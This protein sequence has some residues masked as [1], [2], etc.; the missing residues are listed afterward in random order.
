MPITSTK[1]KLYLGKSIEELN[2]HGEVKIAL[3]ED[4]GPHLTVANKAF[5]RAEELSMDGDEEKSFVLYMRYLNTIALA[6]KTKLY[7]QNLKY[8][9]LIVV[10]RMVQ[11]IDNAEILKDSLLKRYKERELEESNTQ[12]VTSNQSNS[13]EPSNFIPPISSNSSPFI[14]STDLYKLLLNTPPSAVIL[15]CRDHSD[16]KKGVV[17]SVP[18]IYKP[19]SMSALELTLTNIKHLL[20]MYDPSILLNQVS[21]VLMDTQ[22]EELT[23]KKD[24]PLMILRQ[25]LKDFDLNNELSCCP[26]LL[27]GGFESWS[28][29][30]PTLVSTDY[31]PQNDTNSSDESSTTSVLFP[32]LQ[33]QEGVS[34]IIERAKTQINDDEISNDDFFKPRRAPPPIPPKPTGKSLENDENLENEISPSAPAVSIIANVNAISTTPCENNIESSITDGNKLNCV[35]N[36]IQ[37]PIPI[38][39][40]N[41]L[42]SKSLAPTIALN[43][44]EYSGINQSL[45]SFSG[46][47]PSAPPL[48]SLYSQTPII[49]YSTQAPTYIMQTNEPIIP[50]PYGSYPNT[51]QGALHPQQY[52]I[53]PDSQYY[54]QV[55]NGIIPTPP[56]YE[57]SMHIPPVLNYIAPVPN[58]FHTPQTVHQTQREPNLLPSNTAEISVLTHRQMEENN[59]KMELAKK[60]LI[61]M[62]DSVRQLKSEL[63]NKNLLEEKILKLEQ[64]QNYS[65]L[66]LETE[67]RKMNT[68]LAQ[69]NYRAEQ[70]LSMKQK[71]FVDME[72]KTKQYLNREYE[73]IK[74]E[75]QVINKKKDEIEQRENVLEKEQTKLEIDKAQLKVEK[76]RF[77]LMKKNVLEQ[78]KQAQLTQ[79]ASTWNQLLQEDDTHSNQLDLNHGLPNAWRKLFDSTTGRF[80][81]QNDQTKTTH[82][83]PPTSWIVSQQPN[84]MQGLTKGA[85][86]GNTAQTAISGT[87]Q[88]Q[89]TTPPADNSSYTTHNIIPSIDRR[90][91]PLSPDKQMPQVPSRASK[92]I[93]Q[94][95]PYLP[96][97][98]ARIETK[99]KN[100]SLEAVPGS[101]GCCL[102]GLNNLGNT[103]F[104]NSIL[105]CLISTKTLSD[106]FLSGRYVSD[107]NPVNPLGMGGEL[108]ME[109]AFIVQCLWKGTYKSIAPRDFKSTISKFA[110]QFSGSQQ[111]DSQEFLAFLLDGLHED[112]NKVIKKEY[113]VE[114][115]NDGV[116]DDQASMIS[117]NIHLRLND[118]IIVNMLQGQFKSTLNCLHCSYQSVTFEA[119]MYLSVPI[120]PKIF[121]KCSLL[122][123]IK[124]FS[125]LEKVSGVNS[126]YCKKCKTH[127][128]A[129]KRIDIWRLPPILLIH[130]KRFAFSGSIKKKMDTNIDFPLDSL[131]LTKFVSSSQKPR[132]YQLYAVSNHSGSIDSG[133]YTAYVR[134]SMTKTFLKFDDSQVLDMASFSV[135]SANGYVLFYTSIN[136]TS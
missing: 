103:C 21:L 85:L 58:P 60:E 6:K 5:E 66:E 46:V 18:V 109:Y 56:S 101:K 72:Q 79:S 96:Q 33:T 30:F 50:I 81:Y 69:A 43:V 7:S 133:H 29:H 51:T 107:I 90:T 135:Q 53:L 62:E 15:D 87:N 40:S 39:R 42:S 91:K 73:T 1:I 47:L 123:C 92:N 113:I 78:Q 94:D 126:W 83:N 111:H 27:D 130:I 8:K 124:E 22:S 63:A 116:P 2:K 20:K 115:S 65:Q 31:A 45:D 23:T 80:Y 136:F 112:L 121:G 74:M 106:Y 24:H 14:S 68:E 12:Q 52:S 93:K 76:E 61:E 125:K 118:S 64:Q 3:N 86:I 38:P 11:A 32:E 54:S 16:L 57:A 99:N 129:A 10:S 26:M 77:E 97:I 35:T 128:D 84:I 122:D 89:P 34:P 117:W 28:L 88:V 98:K 70:E 41:S 134:N 75:K 59:H 44:D 82:W 110:P 48:P 108:A 55:P 36:I 114:P 120:P 132:E 37:P 17:Y 131:N 19:E 127:R 71:Q 105:Q 95:N 100:R 67:R 13:K 4:P 102:T 49:P 25:N 119:F 9:K 104:M